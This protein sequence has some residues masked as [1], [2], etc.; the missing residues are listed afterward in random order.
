MIQVFCSA[1]YISSTGKYYLFPLL[2]PFLAP[3][4]IA[5]DVAKTVNPQWKKHYAITTDVAK[6]DVFILPMDIA[7]YLHT[8][9]RQVVEEF[10]TNAKQWQ[11]PCW[12]FSGG[13]YGISWPDEYV[14]LL[15]V[16]KTALTTE[17]DNICR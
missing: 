15:Q 9:Q 14:Q 17:I 4:T 16:L 11:K 7:W 2:E 3:A 1:P 6:A 8:G 12:I 10:I 13:D 5:A